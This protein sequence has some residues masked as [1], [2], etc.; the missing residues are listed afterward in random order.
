MD[1][2]SDMEPARAEIA[3]GRI[4]LG[5]IENIGD[6]EVLTTLCPLSMDIPAARRFFSAMTTRAK[7]KSISHPDP[8]FS[9]GA[10]TRAGSAST[11]IMRASARGTMMTA[12]WSTSRILWGRSTREKHGTT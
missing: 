2:V 7:A 12:A 4:L 8:Q 10:S 3:T 11:T 9:S 6:I 1:G 5:V